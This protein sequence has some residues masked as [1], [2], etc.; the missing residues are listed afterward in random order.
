MSK[1]LDR[2]VVTIVADNETDTLSSPGNAVQ[3][4]E[5]AHIL[6]DYPP[7]FH[8]PDGNPAVSVFDHLCFGCHG[9]S[10]LLTGWADDEK[11]TMLFDVGPDANLW[12]GNA[13]K[14][15]VKLHEIEVVFL[16]HWHW[17]HSGGFVGAVQA[18]AEARAAS[19]LAPPIVDVHP[20]R[21]QR[22][23]LRREGGDLMLLPKD[24]TI[25]QLESTG[26]TVVLNRDSHQL[27]GGMFFASGAIARRTSFE[28]GLVGHVS[29]FG[30]GFVDDPTIDDERFVSFNVARRGTSVLSACSH[31]G[32]VNAATAA[33][34]STASTA[35]SETQLDGVFG[36]YHLSGAAMEPRI[37]D[38]VAA[39]RELSPRIVAPGHCTGWRAKQALA[40]AF[41][42]AFSPSVVGSSYHLA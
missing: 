15:Q 31:A 22:R 7:E 36:G 5:I 1:L 41:P 35:S 24:P 18:I 37:D 9:Y 6:D 2:A 39:L 34:A 27:G 33:S 13:E 28:T 21:P 32:V 20:D 26:A 17:D 4:P 3:H 10:A 14:L 8:L 11:A 19:G 12:L 25:T 23:G 16:S 42:E 40:A 38:T 29:D 30:D